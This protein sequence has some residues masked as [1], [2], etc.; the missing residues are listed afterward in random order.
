MKNTKNFTSVSPSTT[1]WDRMGFYKNLPANTETVRK[2][3]GVYVVLPGGKRVLTR[4]ESERASIR[5]A[6]NDM[7]VKKPV[8]VEPKVTYRVRLVKAKLKVSGGKVLN[9]ICKVT[10]SNGVKKVFVTKK[11]ALAWIKSVSK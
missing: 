7:R 10:G 2:A 1:N 6:L 9:R 3:G 8:V 5:K 4:T 11:A